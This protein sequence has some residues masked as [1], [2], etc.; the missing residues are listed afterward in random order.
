MVRR[1]GEEKGKT[2]GERKR[3]RGKRRRK[4]R[5]VEGQSSLLKG[6]IVCT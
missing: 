4:E 6:F 5:G 1:E 3:G 2:E